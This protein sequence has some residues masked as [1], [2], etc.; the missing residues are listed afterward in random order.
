MSPPPDPVLQT[1]H[2]IEKLHQLLLAQNHGEFAG[3]V[4]PD[5]AVVAPRHLQSYR[6]EKL[7]CR[8]ILIDAL[9]RELSLI[10]QVKLV[11]PHSLQIQN[12]RAQPE[13]FCELG[14]VMDLVSLSG[15]RRLRSCISSI[16][17]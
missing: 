10:D 5:K 2:V 1:G 8:N 9:W 6:V 14:Y 15:R 7:N 16:I 3:A 11:L 17:L 4:C 12:F 13:I